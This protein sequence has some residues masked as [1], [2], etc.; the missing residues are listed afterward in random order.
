MT[1][2]VAFFEMPENCI[3]CPCN[4]QAATTGILCG[5]T[6]KTWADAYLH[7]D[8]CADFCPLEPVPF[9]VE[10]PKIGT[11]V[12]VVHGLTHAEVLEWRVDEIR[13]TQS[14][15]FLSLSN[16]TGGYCCVSSKHFKDVWFFD[17]E[18]AQIRAASLLGK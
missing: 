2:T 18:E 12:Y 16:R 7:Q 14:A 6:G 15:F 9:P 17:S 10:I 1:Q 3:V 4:R 11:P 8:H 13:I 5:L